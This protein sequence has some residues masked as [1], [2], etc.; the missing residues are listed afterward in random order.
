M[1]LSPC[2]CLMFNHAFPDRLPFYRRVYGDR[3][4]N[5]RF[6]QP[7][8]R[9]PEP[10][11]I[12]VYRGCYTF[13]AY[14]TD[15]CARLLEIDCTHYVFMHDDVILSP[16]LDERNLLE[17]LDIASAD[18]GFLP[19]FGSSEADVGSWGWWPGVLWRWF[20]PRNILSG[21]GVDNV[22]ASLAALPPREVAAEKMRRHGVEH[23]PR[24]RLSEQTLG[25]WGDPQHFP[26][27][28]RE[29][30][31][32]FNRILLD[33]LYAQVPD[34]SAIEPPYPIAITGYYSDFT[35]IPKSALAEV[36]HI[37]GVLS[38][39]GVVHEMVLGTAMLLAIDKIRTAFDV[40]VEFEWQNAPL[41]PDL[42]LERMARF[43]SLIASHPM[44]LSR[45]ADWDRLADQL[46]DRHTVAIDERRPHG[47]VHALAPGFDPEEYHAINP[48]VPVRAAYQHYAQYG[49][50]EGRQV[51]A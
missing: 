29:D 22:E 46:T 47:I 32:T 37:A 43:P 25:M 50:A 45:I 30:V 18:E 23:P 10:D 48:D 3:F 20:Y 38:A 34:G 31:T 9:V 33:G 24:L 41:D 21:T 36:A 6:I 8:Q 51:R 12:T 1:S 35:V 13:P 39:A 42:V 4:S 15:A 2:F 27:Q 17:V 44:K 19:A 26:V 5:L 40:G 49:H 28:R 7:L 14:I 11:V 16:A